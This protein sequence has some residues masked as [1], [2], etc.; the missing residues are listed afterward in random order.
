MEF[1]RKCE[2]SLLG[3]SEWSKLEKSWTSLC[4]SDG[5][6]EL[7]CEKGRKVEGKGAGD[8]EMRE[9]KGKRR[10]RKH[11]QKKRGRSFLH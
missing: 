1:K 3:E 10:E 2:D 6:D 4:W 7:L 11:S 8:G 5:S 9:Q